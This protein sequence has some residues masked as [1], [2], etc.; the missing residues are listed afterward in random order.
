MQ[1][2][3]ENAPDIIFEWLNRPFQTLSVDQQITV[4]NFFS[5]EEFD[6]MHLAM[7]GIES[8]KGCA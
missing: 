6:E 1:D 7:T 5:A 4:L 3:K 8:K 2:N